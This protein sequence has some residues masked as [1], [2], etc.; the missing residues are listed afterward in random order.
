M[1]LQLGEQLVKEKRPKER[2]GLLEM[3]KM[4]LEEIKRMKNPRKQ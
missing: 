2:E 3:R 4:I 1:F